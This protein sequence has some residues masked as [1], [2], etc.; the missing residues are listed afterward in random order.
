M[1]NKVNKD[2]II[3]GIESS[4][5]DTS[6][7][8][9]KNKQIL[10]NIVSNQEVHKQYG[11]VVPELASREHQKNI[12]PTISLALK[13][14]NISKK[15]IDAIAFTKGP[16]LMGSLLVGSSFAKSVALA[17]NKPL[18]E[19]NHMEAHVLA[20]FIDHQPDFPL[21]CLT[22][23]GGHT[24][25]VRVDALNKIRVLGETLDDSAGETFDKCAKMLGLQYPGGPEIEKNAK[26]GDFQAYKFT[27]PKVDGLNFSFSG[28]KTSFMRLVE[29]NIKHNKLFILE[30][31]QNLCASIQYTII[32][33]LMQKLNLA[34]QEHD[35]KNIAISGGVAANEEFRKSIKKL[36]K[37]HNT[38]VLI[39]K[40]EYSTDNGAMIAIAGYYK[41]QVG[42]F[43]NMS[44]NVDARSK[45]EYY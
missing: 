29:N 21:I 6:V 10:S 16:G 25:I 14:A 38:K 27:L 9:S 35:V 15:E 41:Y 26:H 28:L 18:I 31:K 23:S 13:K 34:I 20:N 11:G 4:C 37:T 30:N 12:I 7:A 33:I 44:I 43:A 19:I 42:Q 17:L 36:E 39:P 32:E 2:I 5:D 40:K 45:L 22:V 8:V 24:Q 3:L 1:F